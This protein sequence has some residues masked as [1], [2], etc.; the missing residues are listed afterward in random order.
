MSKLEA[1]RALKKQKEVVSEEPAPLPKKH[2]VP[3]TQ[4]ALQGTRKLHP[5]FY[6]SEISKPPTGRC[7][8][9]RKDARVWVQAWPTDREYRFFRNGVEL[10]GPH[11]WA[12][13]TKACAAEANPSARVVI[14][15]AD[16]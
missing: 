6:P 11:L 8:V 9:C 2:S 16:A 5:S 14:L 13:C 10:D 4:E 15:S 12:Y 1:L 7:G 3:R